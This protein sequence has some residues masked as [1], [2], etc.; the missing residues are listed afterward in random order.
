MRH[1]MKDQRV[2]TTYSNYIAV[3]HL[4]DLFVESLRFFERTK[5]ET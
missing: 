4:G 2:E 1:P 5:S 3:D